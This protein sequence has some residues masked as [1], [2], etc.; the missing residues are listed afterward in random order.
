VRFGDR[1][2]FV[3][4]IDPASMGMEIPPMILQPLIENAVKYGIAP[5]GDGGTVILTIKRN[6]H[7]V[8]FEVKDDGLGINAIK[9][10]DAT[11]TGVGVKNTNERLISI[12][13][14]NSTL[15]IRNTENGYTVSFTIP[16]HNHL[17]ELI[18]EVEMDVVL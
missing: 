7:E 17:K 11:S 1:L 5:K 12:Y 6:A 3:K 2:Q 16:D 13:G 14:P 9:E 4:H 8:Y 15:K 18:K 10:L